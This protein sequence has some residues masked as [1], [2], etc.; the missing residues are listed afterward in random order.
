MRQYYHHPKGNDNDEA[1]GIADIIT[2]I[3]QLALE[4]KA[5]VKYAFAAMTVT[6]KAIQ[7]N[8]GNRKRRNTNEK[9]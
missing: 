6:I 2:D 3:S 7:E 8:R 9:K 1:Q 5:T 4:N